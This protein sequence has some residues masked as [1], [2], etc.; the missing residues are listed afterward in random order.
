VLAALGIGAQQ[1]QVVM[2][3]SRPE[4]DHTRTLQEGDEVTVLAPIGGG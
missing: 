1:M 4:R 2:V 3:N